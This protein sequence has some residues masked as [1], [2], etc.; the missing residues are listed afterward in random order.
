MYLMINNDSVVFN[1]RFGGVPMDI[2]VPMGAV[3]GIY[4]KENGQGMIFDLEDSDPEPSPP[5]GFKPRAVEKT[6]SS[7]PPEKSKAG[8]RVVK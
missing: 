6:S 2:F 8:L 4:A 3:M 7:N 5:E 1:G